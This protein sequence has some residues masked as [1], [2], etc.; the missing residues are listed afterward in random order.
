MKIL[1][2]LKRFLKPKVNEEEVCLPDDSPAEWNRFDLEGMCEQG[3]LTA[4][5]ACKYIQES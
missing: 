4:L 1:R 5:L 2:I 3:S